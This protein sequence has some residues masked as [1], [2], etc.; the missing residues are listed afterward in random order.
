MSQSQSNPIVWQKEVEAHGYPAAESYLC[1]LYPCEVAR[2]LV[3]RLRQAGLTQFKG[4][5]AAFAAAVVP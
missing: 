1:L 3:L 4:K 5:D 2:A